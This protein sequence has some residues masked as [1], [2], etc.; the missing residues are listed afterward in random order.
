M[1]HLKLLLTTVAMMALVV[2]MPINS[3]AEEANYEIITE[4]EDMPRIGYTYSGSCI[5]S[6]TVSVRS[7]ITSN[8]YVSVLV[9]YS[10]SLGY[11]WSEGLYSRFTSGSG[12]INSITCP[13]GYSGVGFSANIQLVSM[14]ENTII[15]KVDVLGPNGE[16]LGTARVSYMVDEYGQVY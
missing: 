13:I 9:N 8:N 10:V 7:N 5:K 4:H 15:F 14:N 2:I 6:S 16:Y 11:Q 1:R 3:F 12:T